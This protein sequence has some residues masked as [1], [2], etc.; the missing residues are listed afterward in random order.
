MSSV[1]VT[2]LTTGASALAL[3]RLGRSRGYHLVHVGSRRAVLYFVHEEHSER[4]P[5]KRHTDV[6]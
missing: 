5:E 4:Q 1:I 2:N 3:L 6:M